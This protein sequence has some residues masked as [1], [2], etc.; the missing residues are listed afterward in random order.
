MENNNLTLVNFDAGNRMQ[1]KA[2]REGW[3]EDTDMVALDMTDLSD[4]ADGYNLIRQGLEKI[5]NATGVSLESV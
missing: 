1:E 3:E 4:I 5:A 2:E